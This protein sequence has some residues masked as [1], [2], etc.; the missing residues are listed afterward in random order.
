MELELNA[1]LRSAR[2]CVIFDVQWAVFNTDSMRIEIVKALDPKHGKNI[3]KNLLDLLNQR[4]QHRFPPSPE[5]QIAEVQLPFPWQA[6]TIQFK[7]EQG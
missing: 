2:I 4:Q 6:G 5:V 7:E 1:L 3:R